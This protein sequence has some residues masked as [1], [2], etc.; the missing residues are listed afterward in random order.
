[1]CG[2]VCALNLKINNDLIINKFNQLKKINLH[3]GPDN[4]SFY[5]NKNSQV[6]FRRLKIIELSNK[7]NQ[8]F[9]NKD[10]VMVFNGEIYNYIE[11]KKS[12]FEKGIQFKT[13]SDTE[14]VY[15][16]FKYYGIDF[17]K[18]LRGMFSIVILDIKKNITY[19]F[20]DR[21]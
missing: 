13:N 10:F 2:F 8:P 18:Q 17:V 3:R 9:C 15:E 16:L 14:V 12:L 11:L 7:A 5:Q 4:I 1:M 20:R 6:L 21:F 19:L